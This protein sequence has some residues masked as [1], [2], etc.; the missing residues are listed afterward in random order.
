MQFKPSQASQS[1]TP[2]HCPALP[3]DHPFESLLTLLP[4]LS[5]RHKVRLS[6]QSM[7]PS[8]QFLLC[9]PSHSSNYTSEAGGKKG[10]IEKG[11]L[12]CSDFSCW[13]TTLSNPSQVS[14]SA[15]S[16]TTCCNVVSN[17]FLQRARF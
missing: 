17:W 7:N 14:T 3:C 15:L 6:N 2:C 11:K 13:H 16:T 12:N 10:H 5:H 9:E 4:L 1:S 8:L